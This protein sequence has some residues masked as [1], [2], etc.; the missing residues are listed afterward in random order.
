VPD[1]VVR[2]Y[3]VRFGDAIL[4]SIPEDDGGPTVTRHLLI[5]VGNVNAADEGGADAVF[6]ATVQA[7]VDV[8]GGEVD[9]YVM[10]HEHLDHCQGL[11][12]AKAKKAIDLKAKFAWLTRSADPDYYDDFDE[13]REELALASERYHHARAWFSLEEPP[14]WVAAMLE[15]NNRF[16]PAAGNPMPTRT[17]DC[18]DHLR[19]IAPKAETHYVSRLSTV[20]GK[21][22]FTEAQLRILAPEANTAIYYT[23]RPSARLSAADDAAEPAAP[24]GPAPNPQP[25]AGVDAGAFFD[26]VSSREN[27]VTDDLLAIDQAANDTSIVLELEWR[28]WR[29]LFPGDAEEKSWDMMASKDVLRPVHFV[30]I[31]HHGSHNGTPDDP[32]LNL[33]LPEAAP[34]PR[35]RVAAVST[36]DGTYNKVPDEIGDHNTMAAYRSRCDEVFDTRTLA[37]GECFEIRFPG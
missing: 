10:T 36:F 33:V 23:R 32:L 21:H 29:L 5:D 35:K 27:G 25:P 30:K 1:L 31:G 37:D 4:V 13:A 14:P 15:N 19:T 16:L 20:A 8:T 3:N 7:I 34:D 22:P 9:L 2:I 18:V 6:E 17:A 26:L 11:F 28:G 24:P 12:W